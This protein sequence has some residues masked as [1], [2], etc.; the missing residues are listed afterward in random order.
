MGY[1]DLANINRVIEFIHEYKN[2]GLQETG[3]LN[4]D[5]LL[6]V[7]NLLEDVR[8]EIVIHIE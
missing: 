6:N 5:K 2:C 8:N 7:L 3:L 4:D 1:E